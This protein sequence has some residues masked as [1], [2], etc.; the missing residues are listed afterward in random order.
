MSY[1]RRRVRPERPKY[2][3]AREAL[4]AAAIRTVAKLG[5]RGLTHRAVAAEAGVSYGTVAHHFGSREGLIAE[6]MRRS[7]VRAVG[8]ASLE[9]RAGRIED[10][11]E[12]LPQSVADTRDAHA[13]QFELALE[14]QRDLTLE[15]A[16]RDLYRLYQRAVS[17]E[18][19]RIGF[20]EDR[21]FVRLVFAALD[22]LVLQQVIGVSSQ[23]QVERSLAHL[24]ETLATLAYVRDH[25]SARD[26]A[27]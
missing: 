17:R 4:L 26:A 23:R 16:V 27:T 12:D 22:G 20:A 15:P 2:G 8:L 11:V 25:P 5:L 3:E 14:A 18:L 21:A 24:R 13:F 10:F 19:A 1:D 9:R 6:A 7:A